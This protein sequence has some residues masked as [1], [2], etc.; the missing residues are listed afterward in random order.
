MG[1]VSRA[2]TEANLVQRQQIQAAVFPEGVPFNGREFGTAPT[3]IAFM[4][5][6]EFWR[7][8]K[9]NGVPTRLHTEVC[10]HPIT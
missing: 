4:Q 9:W 8:K 1:N 3:C 6:E 5:L 10:P 7:F 2:W